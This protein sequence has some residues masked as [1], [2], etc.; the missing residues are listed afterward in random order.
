[1]E[2][3]TD[4]IFWGSIISADGDCSHEIKRCL[5]LGRKTMTNTDSILKSSGIALLTKVRLI[6]AMVFP[7]AMYGCES[8]KIKK[9]EC[10][11]IDALVLWCWRKLLTVPW[12]ARKSSQSVKGN[13][14]WIL[15]GKT[16]AEAEPP[17]LWLPDT[18]SRLTGQDSDAGKDWRQEEKRTRWLDSIPNSM[19]L[20]LSKL[21]EMAK[22]REAWHSYSPWSH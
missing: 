3:V 14:T 5:L 19:E 17:I 10:W 1:M 7:V 15:I 9:A 8:W 6:K 13:P 4:F 22:D 20:D 11:R 16:D 18:K 12:T 21:W 2:T